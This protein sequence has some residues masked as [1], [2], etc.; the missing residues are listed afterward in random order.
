MLNKCNPYH[1]KGI[2]IN[3]IP[4]SRKEVST[5]LA[6]SAIALLLMSSSGLLL[7]HF[8][9]PVQASSIGSSSSSVAITFRTTEP[10]SGVVQCSLTSA[11]LTFDAQGTP[12]S[13]NPQRVDITGGTFQISDSSGRQILYSG[14][15]NNGRFSNSSSGGEGSLVIYTD[16]NQVPNGTSACASTRDSLTI[17]TGACSTSNVNPIEIGFLGQIADGFGTFHGP[18]DCSL[19]GGG[20]GETATAQP[21]SS[22]SNGTGNQTR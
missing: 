4:F 2:M 11:T 13:S 7:S 3:N 5:F 15:I 10:A 18:V 16:V 22:S 8:L 1:D 20:G 17:D 21:S 6:L 12:S 14:N 9:Q 19:G